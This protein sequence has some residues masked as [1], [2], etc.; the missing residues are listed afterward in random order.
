M[1]LYYCACTPNKGIHD[2]RSQMHWHAMGDA[3]HLHH[4][5]AT[6]RIDVYCHAQAAPCSQALLHKCLDI[7]YTYI[8]VFLNRGMLCVQWLQ[9]LLQWALRRR[10]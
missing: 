2:V 6:K 7:Y 10:A 4:T 1:K 3:T 5:H 8:A 9:L